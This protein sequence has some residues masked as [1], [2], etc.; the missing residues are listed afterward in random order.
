V[1]GDARRSAEIGAWFT[2]LADEVFAPLADRRVD[3]AY[4]K[5]IAMLSDGL[6]DFP[7]RMLS[8][9]RAIGE[10]EFAAAQRTLRERFPDCE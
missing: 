3:S 1:A 2:R 6:G 10:D 7:R 5:T 4:D 8:P 9:Y